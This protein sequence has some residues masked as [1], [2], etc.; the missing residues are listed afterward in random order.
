M[1][2]PIII[3]GVPRSGTTLLR[4]LLD[5]HSKIAAASET[6]WIVGG[7][8]SVSLRELL[9]LLTDHRHGPVAN[10][11]GISRELIYESAREFLGKLFDAYA[12][13]KGKQF[14]VLKTPDDVENLDFLLELFPNSKYIHICRDGRDVACSTVA[15]RDRLG[16]IRGFGE[17]SV[18]NAMR[19]WCQWESSI[20]SAFSGGLDASRIFVTYEQLVGNTPKTLRQICGFLGVD[21]E[22][23][24]V[25]Y[26]STEHD[27]PDWEAGSTDVNHKAN[28][29]TSSVGRWKLDLEPSEMVMIDTEFGDDLVRLGY[30]SCRQELEMDGVSL[31]R[32]SGRLA[33]SVY[34]LSRFFRKP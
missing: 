2:D 17:L 23:K 16:H 27:L 18:V 20:R 32:S 14:V 11:P 3:L 31:P 28:V 29:D 7:Y 6:P 15:K 13:N 8:A 19:R 22:I 33:S 21:Y 4:V 34:R 10:S 5:C 1:F 30:R 24:M 9:E 12:L 25:D 26:K